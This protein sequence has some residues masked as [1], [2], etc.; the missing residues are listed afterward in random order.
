MYQTRMPLSSKILS[1]MLLSSKILLQ[2]KR[3]RNQA[4]FGC[5]VWLSVYSFSISIWQAFIAVSAVL[6]PSGVAPAQ[7]AASTEIGVSG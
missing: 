4:F 3:L 2:K 7:A 5:A 1:H 6:C